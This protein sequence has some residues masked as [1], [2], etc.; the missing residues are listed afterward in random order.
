MDFLNADLFSVGKL[1]GHLSYVLLVLSMMMRSM[2]WLR[3]IA[4]SAGLTSG[5]Y[6]YFWLLDPV[7]VFWEAVFVTV[8]L[9]QLAIIAW[10]NRKRALSE[11]EQI[12]VNTLL[13]S[14]DTRAVRRLLKRGIM[15]EFKPETV[16]VEQ[17]KV[18]PELIVITRGTVQIE[19][20]GRIVGVC[21]EGD[22]IGEMSYLSGETASATVLV[23]NPVHAMAFDHRRLK[24]FLL[25]NIDIR[26]AVEASF[27]RNLLTKLVR[28]NH[29][30]TGKKEIPQDAPVQ[31]ADMP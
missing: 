1:V 9:V 5:A 17:G 16:I 13:P 21:G 29:A 22:L 26:H 7:T 14:A 25:R 20:D 15:R 2:L 8:N 3:I 18:V 10:E 19:K 30:M 23:T 12:V 6:G 11:E 27:N 31:S 28:T 4:V 24:D